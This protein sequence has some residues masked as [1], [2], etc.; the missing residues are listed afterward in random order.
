MFTSC[1][2]S[3]RLSCSFGWLENRF[4]WLPILRC[5]QHAFKKVYTIESIECELNYKIREIRCEKEEYR[6]HCEWQAYFGFS[7][8]V[9]NASMA[10]TKI[11]LRRKS[12]QP[13]LRLSW[14]GQ[15]NKSYSKLNKFGLCLDLLNRMVLIYPFDINTYAISIGVPVLN[16]RKTEWKI[17]WSSCFADCTYDTLLDQFQMK[18]RKAKENCLSAFDKIFMIFPLPFDRLISWPPA[19]SSVPYCFPIFFPKPY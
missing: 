3:I 17:L 2:C 15:N 18:K 1:S 8:Q 12:Q 16:D 11:K 6:W 14:N 10:Y 9:H 13:R 5:A 4:R 7:W 19:K